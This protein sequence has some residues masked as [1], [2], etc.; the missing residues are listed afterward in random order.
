MIL[1]RDAI[2]SRLRRG[3]IFKD[4]TWD[5]R[6]IKEASC[7]L[8]VAADGLML[9]G[10]RYRAGEDLL[11]GEFEIPPGEIAILSTLERL[12]MPG[13]LVGKLGIRF[14]Y[15]TQ[16]LTGLMGI[17]VDPFFGWGHDEERLY[18]R[19]AN[20][21]NEPIPISVGAE[22]F[23]F[24]LHELKWDAPL[25]KSPKD[26]MWLRLQDT[27]G[28]QDN[29]NWSNV[30]QVQVNVRNVEER[31]VTEI[32]GIRNYLQPLVMFGIFLVAAT[33]LGVALSVILSVRDTPEASVPSWV[34]NC[35]WILLMFTL[36]MATTATAAIG[37]F[38]V[39]GFAKGR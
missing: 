15:A 7:A 13:D 33:I 24:E 32:R 18:I 29:S 36:T 1:S 34:T 20:L 39:W 22:V 19:V 5:E 31:L 37:V 11:E 26:A 2:L 4:R 38:T 35:G 30:T 10:K 25:P 27:L 17:Q 16:G 14:D 12:H 9:K 23:T 8:R 6:N 21:G 3:E 28:D